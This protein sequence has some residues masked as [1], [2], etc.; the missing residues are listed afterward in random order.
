MIIIGCILAKPFIIG[1]GSYNIAT[2]MGCDMDFI[3]ILIENIRPCIPVS[4]VK[5]YFPYCYGETASTTL[6]VKV[7]VS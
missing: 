2:I 5:S 4:V 3:R 1:I 6:A 7:T